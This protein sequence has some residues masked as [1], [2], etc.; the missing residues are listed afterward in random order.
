MPKTPSKRL[1]DGS[2]GRGRGPR[3]PRRLVAVGWLLAGLFACGDDSG[4]SGGGAPGEGG[5]GAGAAG[6]AGGS[7]SSCESGS[8]LPVADT[9]ICIASSAFGELY[10][11]QARSP[12][13]YSVF[14]FVEPQACDEFLYIENVVED[15]GGTVDFAKIDL[16]GALPGTC[17]I[18]SN[19][20][21]AVPHDGS[22][23]A[24]VLTRR[25]SPSGKQDTVA[26]SGQVVVT[27]L[28][29]TTLR[30]SVEAVF[31]GAPLAV[32][33]DAP[34]C[35]IMCTCVASVVGCPCGG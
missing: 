8:A 30:A 35:P 16:I 33:I 9:E 15:Q 4:T 5:S 28:S 2:L 17:P 29:S 31:D 18:T 25:F 23:V 3:S 19:V 22:C 24:V 32:S 26:E 14:A 7:P 34:A 20:D 21:V 6:G 10:I 1:R 27:E 11:E 13:G 12:D